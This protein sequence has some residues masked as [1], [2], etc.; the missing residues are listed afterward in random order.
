MMA[1]DLARPSEEIA[2]L[3]AELEDAPFV[4]QSAAL[5]LKSVKTFKACAEWMKNFNTL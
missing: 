1:L 5:N 3:V 2:D 4:Y